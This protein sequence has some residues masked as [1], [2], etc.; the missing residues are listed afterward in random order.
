MCKRAGTALAFVSADQFTL[1]TGEDK[2]SHYQ[3]NKRVIDHVF[4][5][6]CGIKPFAFGKDEQG[7]EVVAVN[8]RCI[9]GLDLSQLETMEYNGAAL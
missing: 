3:F 6:I 9:D 7:K 1:Q 2:L 4:C 8:L 5:S